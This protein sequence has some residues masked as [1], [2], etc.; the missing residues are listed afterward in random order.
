[1]GRDGG[2]KSPAKNY[3]GVSHTLSAK[4]TAC[5]PQHL[6]NY[7]SHSTVGRNV[8]GDKQIEKSGCFEGSPSL[9]N[10]RCFDKLG[11]ADP[12]TEGYQNNSVFGRF[13]PGTPGFSHPS[14]SR[15]HSTGNLRG[16][17][18]EDKLRE[19]YFM[20]VE[21]PCLPR[22]SLEPLAQPK[23]FAS[24]KDTLY[25]CQNQSHALCKQNQLKTG[26][27]PNQIIEFCKLCSSERQVQLSCTS[28]FSKQ[29]LAL[30]KA[31]CC[32]SQSQTGCNLVAEKLP[33][34]IGHSLTTSNT[35]SNDR[36]IG[37]GLG[38]Q[39]RPFST[40]RTLEW[41]R[42]GSSLQSKRNVS[43]PKRIKRSLSVPTS[44]H[45]FNSVRQQNCHCLPQ[46]PG[47]YKVKS[48]DE[49]DIPSFR[50][51]RSVP[52]PSQGISSPR[53]VQQSCRPSLEIASSP[54]VAS[55]EPVYPGGVY[56][57]WH[58]SD[59][60][61]CLPESAR[62]FELR[63]TRTERQ[64]SCFFEDME[65]PA[66]MGT[67]AAISSTQSIGSPQSGQRRLSPGVTTLGESVLA[68]RPQNTGFSGSIH[69]TTSRR[70]VS[71][72]FNRSTSPT[73]PGYSSRGMEMWGW[74]GDIMDWNSDQIG[75][76][77][78]SWRSSTRKTYSVAWRKW[79]DWTRQHHI[80]PSYP[81]GSDLAK[82][83]ADL[84]IIHKLA[85]NTILLYKSAVSTLC[86]TGMSGKLS[87]HVLVQHVLKSIALKRP[88]AQKC[89][90]WDIDVLAFHLEKTTVD[91][92]NIF[93]VCRH[94]AM[95]LLLSS[96]RRVHDLTLLNIDSAQ[97]VKSDESII[98]WPIYG[99]KTD[100]SDYR[101]SGW[102]LLVNTESKN[103]NPVFWI[104]QVI[105]ILHN[106][107]VS[108]NCNSLFITLRGEVKTASRAIIAGW[109][110][111]LL[112]EANITATPGSTRSAVASKNWLHNYPL[113]DILSRGNW[114]SSNTFQ[115]FYRREV[116]SA[117]TN[118]SVTRLFVPVD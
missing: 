3:S 18:L 115:K 97:C 109:I 45:S 41:C 38:S 92:S 76:L 70:D 30:T 25:V 13:S 75:L 108:V 43:N 74:S 114:R 79:L 112:L 59:R 24:R 11:R 66:G 103:L 77:Q 78:S 102:K 35:F 46:E 42:T 10:F 34:V 51:L 31:A 80:N 37:S 62:C 29:H 17:R 56:K 2:S 5:L 64:S 85:Y 6:R 117:A 33:S 23:V 69:P 104:N 15:D 61:F 110:K 40:V 71:R 72:R 8:I 111:S 93:Q 52:N 28:K 1:M 86:N 44:F 82:F 12:A 4:T 106:R 53:E 55:T 58:P 90:I 63:D 96:G 39:F 99:S 94:T 26:P 118:N 16:S 65:L 116:M 50:D 49:F 32:S 107:R 22:N 105:D 101:Q 73:H 84:H 19:V 36:R 113:E 48:Y 91:C 98:F 9:S 95:L 67:S 14:M 88:T 60:S 21:K 7:I 54:R 87:S 27:E 57:V 47:R 89:P 83:L 100:S 20:P 68:G 81:S